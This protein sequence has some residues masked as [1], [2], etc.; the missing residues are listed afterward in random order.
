[1]TILDW[2]FIGLLSTAILSGIFTLLNML[3]FFR[4]KKELQKIKKQR[5]KNKRKRKKR[6]IRVRVL[7][8]KRRGQ[9]RN[10]ILLL[11]F[12]GIF[13]SSAFYSRYY[14]STHLGERDSEAIVQGYYLLT[15]LDEQM[16][17][18][19]ESDNPEKLRKN[20]YDLSA[21]LASYGARTADPRL[22]EEGESKINR[23]YSN[24]KELGLN[25][26]NQSLEQLQ[27]AEILE[28]YLADV[29]KTKQNQKL[30]FDYFK[31]NESALKQKK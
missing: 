22:T 2:V 15:M 23:L 14:Q 29:E 4:N 21:R 20:I 1:M 30:V 8:K 17:Q 3:F 24:M 31:V 10:A 9:L 6:T 12:T 18:I 16:S 13:V 26:T 11:L 25:L 5:I 7:E 28:G 27:Q 19:N